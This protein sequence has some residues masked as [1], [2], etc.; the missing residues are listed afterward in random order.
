MADP[1]TLASSVGGSSGVGGPLLK[2]GFGVLSS[3][4]EAKS[5]ANMYLYQ[6]GLAKINAD[7]A[8]QNAEYE[9]N[10]GEVEAQHS[11]LQTKAAIGQ[12]RAIQGAS[13][14]DVNSGSA[15]RVQ[16]SERE[17]G[18]N[19]QQVIRANAARRAY[20]YEV[21]AMSDTAQAQMA[22]A[23]AKDAKR[24]GVIGAIGTIIGGAASVSDKWAQYSSTFGK[25]D[26][27]GAQAGGM[28]W[29]DPS[30][31]GFGEYKGA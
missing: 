20:G 23:A 10:V 6:A 15:A 7:I 8:K 4:G 11:G 13:G 22:T 19:N 17:I 26:T 28:Y 21:E 3:L 27:S 12:T 9:R 2:M 5:K 18:W 1:S 24:A 30:L 25:A 29:G 16:S 31:P 14:V